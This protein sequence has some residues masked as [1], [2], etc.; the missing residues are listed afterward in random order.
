MLH[1][2]DRWGLAIVLEIIR[3]DIKFA[4]EMRVTGRVWSHTKVQFIETRTEG[5]GNSGNDL[6]FTI[7]FLDILGP[8]TGDLNGKRTELLILSK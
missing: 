7:C 2:V 6:P 3:T 4:N 1:L 8:F 5:K